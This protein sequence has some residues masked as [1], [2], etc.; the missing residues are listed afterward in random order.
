[1]LSLTMRAWSALHRPSDWEEI[2]VHQH[3]LSDR[4]RAYPTLRRVNDVSPSAQQR[5]ALERFWDDLNYAV[6]LILSVFGGPQEI[7]SR[8]MLIARSRQE[9]LIWLAPIEAMARR[10]LLLAALRAPAPNLPERRKRAAPIES[11]LRDAPFRELS[12]NPADWRVLFNDWP[13]E[14]GLRK[15]RAVLPQP[16]LKRFTDYNAYPLARRLEALVR[17]ARD[18]SAA[19][20]RTA[21]KI[22]ERRGELCFAFARYRHDAMPVQSLLND[23]QRHVDAA[24]WNTS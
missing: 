22:A 7:A 18:P 5:P 8:R 16:V 20:Q 19:I 1:M 6:G 24:L 21:R 2:S 11:A 9:I 23:V 14:S 12:D 15:Q 10:I 4:V 3:N 17:L 13:R